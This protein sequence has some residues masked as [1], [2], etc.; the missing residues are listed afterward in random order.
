[1]VHREGAAVL[2][3]PDDLPPAADDPRLGGAQVVG[4]VAVV[5]AAVGVRHQHPDVLAD[6]LAGRVAEQPLHRRVD[7]FDHAPLVNSDDAV[8]DV[9]QDRADAGLTLP[10]RLF[11]LLAG[12]DFLAREDDAADLAAGRVPGPHFPPDPLHGAVPT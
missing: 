6:D 10:Q 11:R 3:P 8:D 9:V 12:G 2:A 4:Q 1:Q 5:L 7:G